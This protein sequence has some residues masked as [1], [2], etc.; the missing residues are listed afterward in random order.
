[1]DKN[2][3]TGI[4]LMFLLLSIYFQFF[5]STPTSKEG[6]IK[7]KTKTTQDDVF[8]K[9]QKEIKNLQDSAGAAQ[10]LGSFANFAKGDDKE[11]ILENADIKITFSSQGGKIKSVLLKKYLTYEKK[12]LILLDEKSSLMN[13]FVKTNEGKDLDIFKLHFQTEQKGKSLSFKLPIA[14]GKFIEQKYVLAEKGFQLQYDLKF[15]GLEKEIPAKQLAEIQWLDNLKRLEFDLAQSRYYSTVNYSF[16]DGNWTYLTWPSNE[17]V[18]ATLDQKIHW[19][20]FKQKFFTSAIIADNKNFTNGFVTKSINLKND[21]IEQSSRANL[22]VSVADLQS[23]KGNFQFYFG[24]SQYYTLKATEIENFDKNVYLGWSLVAWVSKFVVVPLFAFLE[25]YIANY[26]IIIILM[27]LILKTVLLPLTYSSYKSMAKMKVLNDLL[28]PELDAFKEKNGFTKA[29]LSMEEQQKVNQE[30]MRLYADLGTSPFAA[31][32]GC[33]PLLLQMPILFAMFMF[34][35]SAIELRQESFLWAHDLSTYDSILT[36]PFA[37]PGY[38]SHVSLFTILMTLS[39]IGLTY[40]T[41]QNQPSMNPQMKYMGY[42]LPVVFMFVL[43]S[44]PA[45]LSFYYLVQNLVSMGQQQAIKSFFIDE[46]KIKAKF[47]AYKIKNKDKD[48][49]K[50]TFTDKLVELQKKQQEQMEAKKLKAKKP[51]TD[52]KK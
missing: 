40:Y 21:N 23:G 7:L 38:G 52:K 37:I 14:E 48:K 33:V 27:V 3:L 26:G 35:P 12:P 51:D 25:N 49:K 10:V 29:T 4:L 11:S 13:L 46:E 5:A 42:I 8:Q 24:P 34:F 44:Y 6:D 47:E 31:M 43:N 15:N 16:A 19:V 39:T 32:S 30:Q 9:A 36:L 41:N 2:Q 28:K 17:E 20:A 18:V 45:G 1:M 50:Q 22:K